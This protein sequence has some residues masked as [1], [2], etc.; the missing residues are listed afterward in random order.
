MGTTD[1]GDVS[2]IVPTAQCHTACFAIGTGFHT[3]QLVTQG[4]LPAA[5]KGLILAAKTIAST[6]AD[7]LRNPAIFTRAKAELKKRIGTRS[8]VCPIPRD[9]MPDDL[10]KKPG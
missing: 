10:C 7:C 8:Y 4:K 9:V 3:W 6:A 2:W 5:H 1:V